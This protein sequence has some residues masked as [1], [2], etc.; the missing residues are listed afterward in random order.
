MIL[1]NLKLFSTSSLLI[2]NFIWLIVNLIFSLLLMW[3]I[4]SC[5]IL[6]KATWRPQWRFFILK[7]KYQLGIKYCNKNINQLVSYTNFY[8]NG[9]RDDRKS[10]L[11][12]VFHIEYSFIVWSC[13]DQN[14]VS[15]S[16]TKVEYIGVVNPRIEEVWICNQMV[17][18]NFLLEI[19]M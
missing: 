4:N 3:S 9:D 19:P 11:G 8:W 6:E 7:G 12:Y 14:I 1:Q 2:V 17:R 15:L 10:T 18:L 16:T 5:N 13:K